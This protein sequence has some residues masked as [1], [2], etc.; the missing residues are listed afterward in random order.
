MFSRRRQQTTG[1]ERRARTALSSASP[2]SSSSPLSPRMHPSLTR[3]FRASS[4]RPSASREAVGAILRRD[5][6]GTPVAAVGA[7]C[8][9]LVCRTNH[10]TGPAHRLLP[11]FPVRRIKL[12]YIYVYI[13]HTTTTIY[14]YPKAATMLGN[15]KTNKNNERQ[16][17]RTH[18]RAHTHIRT[19]TYTHTHT[20]WAGTKGS[21][22]PASS[23]RFLRAS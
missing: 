21:G 1:R 9:K 10:R 8:A 6:T 23:G 16:I 20:H 3:G 18:A 14:I 12:V 19:H 22:G 2:S 7:G 4:D 13:I 15:G 5:R 17:T 11:S